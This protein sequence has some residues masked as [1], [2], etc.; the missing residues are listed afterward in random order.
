MSGESYTDPYGHRSLRI[1][2]AVRCDDT[3][4]VRITAFP[5]G[6]IQI[7]TDRSDPDG[8]CSGYGNLSMADALLLRDWLDELLNDTESDERNTV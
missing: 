3:G 4:P 8:R 7:Y 2:N 6:L 5:T 1:D